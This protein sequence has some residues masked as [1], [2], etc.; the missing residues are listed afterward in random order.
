MIT[1]LAKRYAEALF[2]LVETP[3]LRQK[4]LDELNGV[5][6]AF[7]TDNSVRDLI[8]SPIY[9]VEEKIQAFDSLRKMDFSKTTLDF[10][11]LLTEKGRLGLITQVGPAFQLLIDEASAMRRGEVKSAVELS[12]DE[13]KK[14][15]DM[16]T[17][18]TKNKVTLTFKEDPSLLGG[19][20]AQVGGW[21]FDDT[22]AS[23]L[24]R[25]NE[26]LKRNH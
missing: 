4:T 1:E 14:I 24:R 25:M 23:H 9:S 13:K 11:K 15:E 19:I 18:V 3:A 20:V 12:A 8:E 6:S 22:V 2:S 7:E 10:L 21:T 16:I 17:Q 26:E 5:A